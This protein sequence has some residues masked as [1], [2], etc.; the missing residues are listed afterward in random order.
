MNVRNIIRKGLQMIMVAAVLTGCDMMTEDLS[1]C[2]T[3]LYVNFVYDYNTQRADMFKDHVGAVTL[4]VFDES[5]RLVAQ[6]T[7]SGSQLSVYGYNI[8]FTER[9][10]APGHQYRLTAVALQKD[11]DEAL[12]TAGAKYRHTQLAG[13]DS[14]QT[15]RVSLDRTAATTPPYYNVSAEAP[16]DTLWHTLITTKAEGAAQPAPTRYHLKKDGQATTNGQETFALVSGEPT[17]ATVSLIRYTKHL[18]I[19]LRE[20]D[21]PENVNADDYEVFILDA[22][23]DAGCD[24]NMI[25]PTDSLVYRPYAQWTSTFDAGG[26]TGTERSAH[27]DLMFNRLTYNADDADKNAVLCIRKKST[28]ENVATINLPYILSE[29]RTA[30]EIYSYQPQ[31][32]L[33]REYDYRLEFFLRGDRWQYICVCIDVL[34]WAKRIQYVEL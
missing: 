21:T 3:G 13:G 25:T 2:P 15:L 29:G 19:S 4:Y 32:Y 33:D 28:G 16:L 6:R 8:H 7:V 5:D 12:Q 17:Y 26:K 24:N 31:E 9:E 14:R 30:Y 10:L 18:N 27:Y 23:G 34:S 1:D 22:N 11:W 20:L